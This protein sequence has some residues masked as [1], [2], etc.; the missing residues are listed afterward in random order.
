MFS[1]LYIKS[2]KE[3]FVISYKFGGV[4]H[5]QCPVHDPLPCVFSCLATIAIAA[6]KIFEQM[7]QF[8]IF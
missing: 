5:I 8:P 7:I 2:F 1:F 4:Y 6:W 3:E